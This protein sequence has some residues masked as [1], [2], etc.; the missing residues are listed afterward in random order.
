[1]I[2]GIKG[3]YKTL[4][5]TDSQHNNALRNADCHCA[6]CRVSFIVMLSVIML[7]VA[8]LNV[9]APRI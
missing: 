9:T 4:S 7:N 2:R 3:L 1:M 5:I 6:E 8:V